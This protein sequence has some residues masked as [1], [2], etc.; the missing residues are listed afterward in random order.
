MAT[1]YTPNVKLGKP[2]VADRGWNV[3]LDANSDLLDALAPVGGLCVS[4]AEVPSASLNIRVAAGFFPK[5]DG[6]EGAYAGTS[7]YA[8]GDNA[9]WCLYLDASGNLTSN[10]TFPATSHIK[11]AVVVTA[12]ALI[13][14]ITDRRQTANL[15]GNDTFVSVATYNALIATLASKGILP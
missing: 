8:L 14:S 10:A 3:P 7:S 1:T 9:S 6:S 11:L 2:A 13:Q 4:P 12:G 5:S 15:C